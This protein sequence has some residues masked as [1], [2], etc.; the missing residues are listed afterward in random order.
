MQNTFQFYIGVSSVENVNWNPELSILSWSPPPFHSSDTNT[1]DFIYQIILNG[2]S[3]LNTTNNSSHLNIPVCEKFHVSITVFFGQ[4]VSLEK[5]KLINNTGS[6]LHII[7]CRN[8][9][10]ISF[11]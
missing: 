7:Y 2:D 6:K 4:Y 8:E 1:E 9:L 5:S 10:S 11:I 3:L